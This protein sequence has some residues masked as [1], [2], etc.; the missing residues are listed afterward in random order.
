MWRLMD[1]YNFASYCRGK[2]SRYVGGAFDRSPVELQVPRDGRWH[3]AVDMQGLAGTT[4]ATVRVLPGSLPD[5]HELPLSSAVGLMRDVPVPLDGD[6]QPIYDVF[7]SHASEDK[8]EL[9][10]PLATR[11]Q[12]HHVTV[13]YDDLTLYVGDSFRRKVESGFANSRVGLVVI[14]PAFITKGVS[15]NDVESIMHRLGASKQAML[16][17]WH[18]VSRDQ[19][20][21]FSPSLAR[22][23]ARN[24]TLNPIESI[25]GEIAE[26]FHEPPVRR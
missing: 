13:W 18:E 5:V 24:T 10:E 23:V 2:K 12:Q 26:L 8:E 9:V 16:P 20:E 11:L 19:V 6:K 22:K 14:S 3:V 17:I 15:A 1:S 7:I 4:S 21:R 25:A